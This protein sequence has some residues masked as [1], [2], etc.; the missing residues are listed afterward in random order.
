MGVQ[1]CIIN[2]DYKVIADQIEK[3]C[4]ARDTTLEKILTPCKE[5][6]KL[7]ERILS[8][9]YQKNKNTEADE[10]TKCSSKDST[11]SRCILSDN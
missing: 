11:A 3:E 5:N 2:T 7:F 1:N 10:L 6:E 9:A 4:I 8:R